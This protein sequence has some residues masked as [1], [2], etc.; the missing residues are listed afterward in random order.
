MAGEEGRNDPE[1]VAARR[2][3]DGQQ[4]REGPAV[5]GGRCWLEVLPEKKEPNEI[6]AR[7]ANTDEVAIH[8]VRV[9]APPPAHGAR[10]RPVVDADVEP[11]AH[12]IRAPDKTRSYTCM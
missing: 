10:C 2:V 5:Y 11:L 12:A 9:E 6:A 7:R 8:F 1:V 4:M 3:R